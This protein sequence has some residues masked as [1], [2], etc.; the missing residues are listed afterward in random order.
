[1]V[2]LLK[3]QTPSIKLLLVKLLL[4]KLLLMG[5][6]LVEL[7]LFKLLSVRLFLVEILSVKLLTLKLIIVVQK[8][9]MLLKQCFYSIHKNIFRLKSYKKSLK[10]CVRTFEAVLYQSLEAVLQIVPGEVGLKFGQ[11]QFDL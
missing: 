6:L 2:E 7:L 10:I 3:C 11:G 1:M 4:V 8:H 9:F 5:L